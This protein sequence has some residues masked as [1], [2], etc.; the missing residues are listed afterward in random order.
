MR[1]SD[2]FITE[3]FELLQGKLQRRYDC[4]YFLGNDRGVYVIKKY[5]SIEVA[6]KNY[7]QLLIA[8]KQLDE[9][10]TD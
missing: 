3:P 9:G 7:D 10:L 2:N 5:K 4:I 8:L 1:Q 6:A